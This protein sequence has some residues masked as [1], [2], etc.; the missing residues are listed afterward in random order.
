MI[1]K[2]K[3]IIPVALMFIFSVLQA[4]AQNIDSTIERYGNNYGQERTYLHFDKSSYAA[5][6]TIWYKAYLM[7]GIFPADESK[8]IYLDWTDD[9]GRLLSHSMIPIVY[10]TAAGQF[11]IPANYTSKY[12]H[13]KAYTKWML[14]FDSTFLYNKDIRILAK[15]PGVAIQKNAI[16][17]SVQFF[18]EGGDL[19]EGAE[20]TP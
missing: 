14:N 9:K 10:A 6:E 17:P 7:N 4:A 15:I 8:T 3:K 16:I 19:V 5:G 18:P 2:M 20:R 1:K 11:D 12:I 13:V